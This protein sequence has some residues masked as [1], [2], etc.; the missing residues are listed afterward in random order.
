[1]RD[2]AIRFEDS[3]ES[4]SQQTD[5]GQQQAEKQPVL[6]PP[7]LSDAEIARQQEILDATYAALQAIREQH[8]HTPTADQAREQIMVAINHWRSIRQWERAALLAKRYLTDNPRDAQLPTLRHEIARDYLAWAAGSVKPNTPKQLLLDE[9]GQRF[10]LARTELTGII[11]AFPDM[12]S[13]KHQA[14]W[15]IAVSYLSQARVIAAYSST[16]A[17]GQ[18]VRAANELLRTAELYHD[19]PQVNEIPNMLWGIS[20]D[21][22]SRGYFDE[23][24]AVWNEMTLH[25]PGHPLA[26][27][28]ALHIA[29]TY[30]VQ[31][32]QPLRA[33]E[34]YLELNFARGGG[35]QALQTTIFQI[36]SQLMNEKRW[37]E[38][39]HVLET[40]V[41]SFPKHP[42]AGQA[43]AMI[44]RIHQTNEVWGDAIDAY[45]RVILEYDQGPWAKEAKWSIA[46][47]TIN[48]SRWP[49]AIGAYREYQ[50][51]YPDD[52][53]KV[54]E[55]TRRLDV[56]KD[57]AR[58]QKV[59]DEKG[60]RKSFDAQYQIATIVRTQLANPVKAIIEYR[61]VASNW[62]ES[63]SGRRCPVPGGHD[64]SGAGRDRQGAR[65]VSA[66]GRSVSH[67]PAGRRRAVPNWR[68]LR[69][70]GA[71]AGRRDSRQVDRYRQGHRAKGGLPA[72]GKAS[73]ASSADGPWTG[74][75]S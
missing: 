36:A 25:Y 67:Q 68:Q 24:I 8:P 35:D 22:V 13:L 55:A 16:L 54:A 10:E 66:G 47:C 26:E 27:Q 45:R 46:E 73:A 40:F 34:S 51:A 18:F 44:G 9:V 7:M 30:Q 5:D 57:L 19:H 32:S 42:E 52:E 14:Q 56:L 29:Q 3:A 31:L 17:R 61:K 6:P 12:K 69:E 70:R 62:P 50:T 37:V 71:K 23:A 1:M 53:A 48:L 41:D 75:A 72:V 4:R 60:Q 74:S 38:S 63:P 15:E 11:A 65:F 2:D 49:E 33:V 20:Q 28:A 39:L 59:V 43:M 21:L 64:L 58:F